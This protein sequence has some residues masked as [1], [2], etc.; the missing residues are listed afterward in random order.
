[1]AHQAAQLF[2]PR[3]EVASLIMAGVA[4]DTRGL[5]LSSDERFNYYPATPMLI[6]SWVFAGELFVVES[7]GRGG[8]PRLSPRIEAVTLAG[9]QRH[10]TASWSPGPFHALSVG[11]FPDVLSKVLGLRIDSL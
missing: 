5:A 4:R 8:N 2:L 10:P 6:V 3:P 1:M 7:A 11:F 9:P